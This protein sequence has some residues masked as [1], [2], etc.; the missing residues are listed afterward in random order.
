MSNEE[1]IRDLDIV[2]ETVIYLQTESRRLARQQCEALGIT[3]TQLNIIKMLSEIGHLSLSELSRRIASKNST[4]TGIV[5][6]M[7]QADLV[8]RRQS[9]QDRRV[10]YITLTD[11]GKQVARKIKVA[12]WDLLHQAVEALTADEQRTLM[13]ILRKVAA[14]VAAA[15]SDS[16][17]SA[18]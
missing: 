13:T 8:A 14:H 16:Q 11:N 10:W 17:A 2:V 18:S 6:R 12:P 5:D 15:A 9:V 4:V 3:A 7:V 1:N